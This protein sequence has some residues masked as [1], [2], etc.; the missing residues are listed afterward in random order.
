MARNKTLM[1]RR[2]AIGVDLGGTNLRIAVLD[3]KAVILEAVTLPTQV[4]AGPEAA[5]ERMCVAIA[6]LIRGAG[7]AM[8]VGVAVPGVLD[9]D[10]GAIRYTV[11]LPG[12]AGYPLRTAIEQR[13]GL[14][15]RIEHDGA[16][17]VLGEYW[18]GAGRGQRSFC[19]LTLGTGV[20]GALLLDGR[21]WRGQEGFP[22]ELGHISLNPWG[23]PCGCGGLGCL[24]TYASAT[25]LIR[26]AETRMRAGHAPALQQAADAAG[27]IT[28]ELLARMA[29]AGDPCALE[30]W[31]GL[32]SV[33]GIALAMLVHAYDLPL[34]VIGGGVA[35]A[36]SLFECRLQAE[37]QRRSLIYRLGRTRVVASELDEAG[38]IGAAALILLPASPPPEGLGPSQRSDGAYRGSDFSTP[39]VG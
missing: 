13:L 3:D 25:A 2:I 31:D 24:E 7:P 11:N 36:W 12:W 29:Q 30:I 10:A 8:G 37:L 4:A 14:P 23:A 27:G 1:T 18:S 20:G 21:L 9:P 28:P 15:T 5:V 34:Y 32:G 39:T 35:R 6:D 33:L 26:V 19:M 17:A 16:A 22:L 38:L